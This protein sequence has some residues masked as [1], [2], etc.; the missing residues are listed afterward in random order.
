MSRKRERPTRGS[1]AKTP[2]QWAGWIRRCGGSGLRP[3]GWVSV[4]E[5]RSE[6]ECWMALERHRYTQPPWRGFA[7]CAWTVL[8]TG[9]TPQTALRRS[10][11]R[12]LALSATPAL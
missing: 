3:L 10:P 1:G 9:Q 2:E 12:P 8:R 5:A 4:V 7:V 6:A 11:N